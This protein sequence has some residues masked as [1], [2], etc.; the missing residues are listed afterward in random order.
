M[1]LCLDHPFVPE[2]RFAS[3][4]VRDRALADSLA[5]GFDGLWQKTLKDLRELR[6]DPRAGG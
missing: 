6:F 4:M 2:G 3:L 1:I 5:T